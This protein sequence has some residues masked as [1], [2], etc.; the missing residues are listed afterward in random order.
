MEPILHGPEELKDQGLGA[1]QKA[2]GDR[3]IEALLT[4]PGVSDQVDLILTYRHGAPP[5]GEQGHYEAWSRRGRVRFRRWLD[6]RQTS[7][8]EL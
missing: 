3:A 2:S 1:H 6:Q 5:H 7:P 8:R 4:D